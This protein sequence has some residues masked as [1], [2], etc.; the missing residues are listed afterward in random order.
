MAVWSRRAEF[1][2]RR[3]Y[4]VRVA[5]S[6]ISVVAPRAAFLVCPPT[7]STLP[8]RSTV[9]LWPVRPVLRLP[10]LVHVPVVGE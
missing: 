3:A 9:A 2:E 10:T 4:Q 6:Y 5:G 8:L 7:T 1:S